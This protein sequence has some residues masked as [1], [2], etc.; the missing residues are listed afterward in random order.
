MSIEKR[1]AQAAAHL[2]ADLDEAIAEAA[3]VAIMGETE[4][5]AE[6]LAEI[7]NGI[8]KDIQTLLEL[9]GEAACVRS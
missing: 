7:E 4:Q 5:T 9:E 3:S 8:R 6:V 2:K 1:I